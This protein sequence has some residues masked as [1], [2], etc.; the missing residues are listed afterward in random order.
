MPRTKL[1]NGIPVPLTPEE[2]AA[3]DAEEEQF[4][5]ASDSRSRFGSGKGPSQFPIT[6]GRTFGLSGGS[7]PS[8][9]L[10]QSGSLG[11]AGK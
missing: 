6:L 7:Q 2:E 3:R 8:N 9:P 1:V 4:Q 5:S 10:Q 11:R